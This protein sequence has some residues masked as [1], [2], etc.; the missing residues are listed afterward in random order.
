MFDVARVS[1]EN[2]IVVTV[3]KFCTGI[4][5]CLLTIILCGGIVNNLNAR[6]YGLAS[7]PAVG[8]FLND[9]LPYT[10]PA[11]SGNWSA[12]SAFPNLM[13]TNSVGL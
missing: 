5:L 3:N 13:F 4:S 12:V 10:A 1:V 9:T 11:I 7:R 8:P 2:P 6:L